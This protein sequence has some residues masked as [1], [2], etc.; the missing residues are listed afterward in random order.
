MLALDYLRDPAKVGPKP[1]VAIV[2]DDLYLRREVLGAVARQ[3]LGGEA[4]DLALARFPGESAS[5]ADVL[6]EVRTLPFLSK[7]RVAVVE[8]ADPFVTAHRK[9]LES[10][11]ERPST[12]GVLVL[13]V[14]SMPGNTRLAKIIDKAG[15]LVDAKSPAE[16]DLPAWLLELARSRHNLKLDAEAAR[17]LVELV[18]PEVGLLAAELE[19]LAVYVGTHKGIHRDDVATMVG[20]GRVESL[21]TILDAATT[22]AG[23]EALAELD[24]LLGSGE[25]PVKL[26]AGIGASLRKVCHAG[27]LRLR[28]VSD[29]DACREAG[30]PPFAVEK[31]LKQHAHLGPARVSRIPE[32]LLRADLDLKGSSQLPPRAILERLLL[33]L[34]RP[35]RDGRP[36]PVRKV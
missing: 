21:W 15:L 3:A 2:G 33:E 31:T 5:L 12:S 16:K 9:E 1:I 10:Y 30:I 22:G 7:A 24:K 36:A 18:G 27:Q 35:R 11:A 6:D 4:D 32:L 17:L 23:G 20:A 26:L 8:N 19:K 29:R 34:A 14:K 13:L 25:P 28:R